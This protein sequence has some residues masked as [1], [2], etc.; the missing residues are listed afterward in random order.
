M[1]CKYCGNEVDEGQLSCSTCGGL[2]EQEIQTPDLQE[3][4]TPKKKKTKG[5]LIAVIALV[6]T[7]ALGVGGWFGYCT[8][9]YNRAMDL[10][11]QKE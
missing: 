10:V 4:P 1:L 11:A 2:V 3:Q 7:A 9:K 6:L 5:W 8:W